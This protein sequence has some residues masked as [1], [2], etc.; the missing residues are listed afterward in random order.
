MVMDGPICHL[1]S[2]ILLGWDS[3][4]G[5]PTVWRDVARYYGGLNG[6][7]HTLPQLMV[8]EGYIFGVCVDRVRASQMYSSCSELAQGL[9]SKGADLDLGIWV[10]FC[11]TPRCAFSKTKTI[12]HWIM[13]V[14]KS[15][16]T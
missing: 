1:M 11:A 8:W 7:Y 13:V 12:F 5:Q 3:P 15:F 2:F 10:C 9:R 16:S 6:L 14:G 4:T